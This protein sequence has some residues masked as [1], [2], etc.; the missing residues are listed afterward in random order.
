LIPTYNK[1]GIITMAPRTVRKGGH[2]PLRQN[3][4]RKRVTLRDAPEAKPSVIS[5]LKFADTNPDPSN[6][7]EPF[8]DPSW[9]D[10]SGSVI[11]CLYPYRSL[12]FTELT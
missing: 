4:R 3:F 7:E 8:L 5:D 9:P 10:E 6:N 11:V 12:P 2:L 1:S